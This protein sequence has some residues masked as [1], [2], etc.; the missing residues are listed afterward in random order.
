MKRSESYW[1]SDDED[2]G[3]R[4]YRNV[5]PR[6][7]MH[8]DYVQSRQAM[9]ELDAQIQEILQRV[10][11]ADKDIQRISRILSRWPDEYSWWYHDEIEIL[12]YNK[13]H[14]LRK[15]NQLRRQWSFHA[16]NYHRYD[17][18]GAQSAEAQFAYLTHLD[19]I[20]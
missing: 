13:K 7:A 2:D 11:K 6:T 3:P 17:D 16:N 15:V 18:I 12:K 8:I 9:T 20:Q 5:R 1:D 14:D 4:T 10:E 19:N